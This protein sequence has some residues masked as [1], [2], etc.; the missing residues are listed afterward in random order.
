MEALMKFTII[1][2]LPLL[3]TCAALL[4]AGACTGV[5]AATNEVPVP[6]STA[7][8]SAPYKLKVMTFNMRR[9]NGP[10][11][12]PQ[13]DWVRRKHLV[14]Q[15]IKDANPDLICSQ[16][17][18]AFQAE[19]LDAVLP[20]YARI[21]CGRDANLADEH[22][23]IYYKRGLLAPLASE[24][25]WLSETP[26]IPGSRSWGE[27]WIRCLLIGRFYHLPSR[28][29]LLVACTHLDTNG[30]HI[31]LKE[32]AV[33][34]AKIRSLQGKMPVILT[35]DFNSLGGSSATWKFF[36][37][38][39][40]QDSWCLSP[41]KL[42]PVASGGGF[43]KMVKD[44]GRRIDWI[45]FKGDVK[46]LRHETITTERDGHYPSDHFPVTS[47]LLIQP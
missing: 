46:T 24:M 41:V 39:G 40:F 26:E 10:E 9:Q 22:M 45:L 17:L 33:V 35:A 21:G 20:G 2:R 28:T 12:D 25:I 29:Q 43:K 32:A 14:A 34:D 30:E 11:D 47:E 16:E 23:L 36:Q 7:V 1:S 3:R 27:G 5:P 44:S 38:K 31:R 6:Q 42:G 37:E 18:F 13:D 19:E 8:K 15:V 4:L